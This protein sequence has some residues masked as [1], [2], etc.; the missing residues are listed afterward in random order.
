MFSCE[1]FVIFK[2]IFIYSGSSGCF[3]HETFRNIKNGISK[4]NC[5]H[6][7]LLPWI[8]MNNDLQEIYLLDIQSLRVDLTGSELLPV[9]F[10]F[11][12]FD[13]LKK[14]HIIKVFP[15][16]TQ[17]SRKFGYL[18]Q[19]EFLSIQFSYFT[20]WYP[21]MR[22]TVHSETRKAKWTWKWNFIWS[23]YLRLQTDTV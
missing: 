12:L 1:F 21:E 19:K 15:V 13:H 22:V 14:S 17:F 2:N 6:T 10:C 23:V 18:D 20:A 3:W 9:W 11:V 7:G 16:I 8:W 5:L 4:A